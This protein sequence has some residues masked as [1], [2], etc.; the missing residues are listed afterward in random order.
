MVP[1]HWIFG[2]HPYL[3]AKM[4]AKFIRREIKTHDEVERSCAVHPD[5]FDGGYCLWAMVLGFL[6]Q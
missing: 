3:W 6:G 2:Q 4:Q 1:T 5:N